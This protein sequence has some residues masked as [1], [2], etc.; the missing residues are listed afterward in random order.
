MYQREA[1]RESLYLLKKKL[2]QHNI[3]VREEE[4]EQG[5]TTNEGNKL[6][7]D[8]QR[9]EE[10]VRKYISSRN[11]VV[12]D[13]GIEK[14]DL[15][16]KAFDLVQL[17]IKQR[18]GGQDLARD[19]DDDFDVNVINN[20]VVKEEKRQVEEGVSDEVEDIDA[21]SVNAVNRD[22]FEV[23]TPIYIENDHFEDGDHHKQQQQKQK[24]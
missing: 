8:I 13:S 24:H 21:R 7:Q 14:K 11:A 2:H 3:Q 1:L 9:R 22:H 19:G 15:I 6:S 12:G 10:L 18:D 17:L 23:A 4:G 5:G 16:D 20:D